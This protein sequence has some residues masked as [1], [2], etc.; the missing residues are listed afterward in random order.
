MADLCKH[1]LAHSIDKHRVIMAE[2]SSGQKKSDESSKKKDKESEEDDLDA[3]LDEALED[4]D[5]PVP[6][7]ESTTVTKAG[8]DSEVEPHPA[9]VHAPGNNPNND[10]L[11]EAL[12]KDDSLLKMADGFSDVLE[13]MSKEDPE[14]MAEFKK[15]QDNIGSAAN[16]GEAQEPANIDENFAK[17]LNEMSKNLQGLNTSDGEAG[18]E[19]MLK[20]LQGEMGGMPTEGMMPDGDSFMSMMQGMMQNLLTKD[21]LYPSLK[22]I[23]DKYP[24]WLEKNENKIS[25]A[26]LEKY[27]GQELVVAKLCLL[28]EQEKDTDSDAVKTE[29]MDKVM[30]LMQKMQEYGHPPADM[31]TEVVGEGEQATPPPPPECSIM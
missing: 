19:D 12:W 3:L 23:K 30:E 17:T 25:K 20:Q 6:S 8:N 15:F 11:F 5:K 14:M 31:M 2:I 7:T 16:S 18:F 9:S 24:S 28:F 29:R 1:D 22:E 26:E 21:L 13:Q 27:K 4:F 10:P